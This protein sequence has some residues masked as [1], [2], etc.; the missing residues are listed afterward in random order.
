M[1]KL[2]RYKYICPKCGFIWSIWTSREIGQKD[3]HWCWCGEKVTY[4]EG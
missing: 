2:K 4:G 3:N 1:T